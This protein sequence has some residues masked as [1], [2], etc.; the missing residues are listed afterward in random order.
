M[1]LNFRMSHVMC[2]PLQLIGETDMLECRRQPD[3]LPHPLVPILAM[4][5]VILG[6]A[7]SFLFLMGN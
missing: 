3:R 2:L 6:L 1:S 7:S 5:S 4:L